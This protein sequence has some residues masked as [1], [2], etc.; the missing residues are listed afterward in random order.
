MAIDPPQRDPYETLHLLSELKD[1]VVSAGGEVLEIVTQHREKPD[2]RTYLG[3]GKVE[4]LKGMV[5]ERGATLVVSD[6]ELSASQLR[7]LEE[8]LQVRVIDRSQ[9]ILDIFARRAQSKE[10]KIQVELAQ[11]QYLLPRLVG[12]QRQLS[13]LGGGIG[14]RGPGETKLEVDRRLMRARIHRLKGDLEKVKK[15]RSL[16]RANRRKKDF[17]MV[18][19]LGYTNAGKSCLFQALTGSETFVSSRL[20]STLDPKVRLLKGT[21]DVLLSDTV[22]LIRKIP[23]H[24][25][26][27][28]R[29]TLE[30]SQDADLILLVVDG[31]D[32][33]ALEHIA[34]ARE[35]IA[36][37]GLQERPLW[38]LVNKLD[39]TASGSLT[40]SGRVSFDAAG[41]APWLTLLLRAN[42]P[43][44]AVSATRGDHLE[45]LSTLVLAER[46]RQRKERWEKTLETSLPDV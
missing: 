5:K 36:T 16:I 42:S 30:E 4:E 28:F 7:N 38:T 10:G 12:S 32:P 25:F 27:A 35:V 46:D 1:L 45:E 18:S 40:A 3:Q 19:L 33:K 44:L 39:L 14:T 21:T 6:D 31:S 37:L 22:G 43:S 24:L 41:Y 13:R 26:T 20:F 29:A 34:V 9:V 15:N 8:K 11:L 23:H 17:F 2:A